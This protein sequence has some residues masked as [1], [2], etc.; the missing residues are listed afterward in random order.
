MTRKRLPSIEWQKRTKRQVKTYA[1]FRQWTTTDKQFI[2]SFTEST[3]SPKPWKKLPK[4][5]RSKWIKPYCKCY[6]RV[7]SK[8]PSMG[9]TYLFDPKKTFG[10][11]N[12]AEKAIKQHIRNAS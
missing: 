1:K 10:T 12:A 8:D 4:V 6:I 7:D 9:Y 2:I 5:Q 11:F 3:L